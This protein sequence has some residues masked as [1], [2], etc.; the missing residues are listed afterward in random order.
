MKMFFVH[1]ESDCAYTDEEGAQHDGLAFEVG[2]VTDGTQEDFEEQCR[3]MGVHD[4]YPNQFP[5]RK[6]KEVDWI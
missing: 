6:P 3:T 4:A 2:P 1:P 5:H